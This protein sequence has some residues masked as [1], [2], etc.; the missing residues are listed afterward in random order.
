M[1]NR[2][3]KN[4]LSVAFAVGTLVVA[5]SSRVL[6]D[7]AAAAAPAAPAVNTGNI[8]LTFENDFTNAYFFRGILQERDGGIWEP[9]LG[10]AWKLYN[11]ADGA[12]RT[13][14]LGLGNWDSV[15]SKHTLACGVGSG[16]GTR[17]CSGPRAWYE[18]DIYPSMT[19]TWAYGI[20]TGFTYYFYTS[21]NSGFT[22]TEEADVNLGF[23]DSP[24]L[25]AFALHP[26]ATFA[27]ET[28]GSSFGDFFGVNGRGHG[29]GDLFMLSLAPS[30]AFTIPGADAYPVTV[31]VPATL[32]LSMHNYYETFNHNETFGYASLGVNF[33]I[34]LAFLPATYG[35]WNLVNG[36][37][38]LFLDKALQDVNHDGPDSS[39]HG[40]SV[41]PVWMTSVVMAY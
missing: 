24:Y 5:T 8:S 39:P 1:L 34:P 28:H 7:D 11:S 18:A 21:P 15:H 19:A 36:V 20:T 25:G 41:Y 35:A 6:A 10:I 4:R 37:N 33:G 31:T 16:T 14:S 30:H 12:L 23:D 40:D 29:K 2:H 26:T 3:L 32:A 13:V 22:T 17:S 38:V 27:F 9:S